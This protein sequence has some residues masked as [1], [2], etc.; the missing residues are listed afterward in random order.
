MAKY[1]III[2]MNYTSGKPLR[3]TSCREYIWTVST[4]KKNLNSPPPPLPPECSSRDGLGSNPICAMFLLLLVLHTEPQAAES[5][6]NILG[7]GIGGVIL[8][9]RNK[10]SVMKAIFLL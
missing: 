9:S 1:N 6:E 8:F 5:R 10:Y 4:G 3:S 2:K 7:G